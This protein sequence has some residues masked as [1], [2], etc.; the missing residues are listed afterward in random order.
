M[1][2]IKNTKKKQTPYFDFFLQTSDTNKV[3]GICYEPQQRK[4]LLE[5][6]QKKSPVKITGTKR[7]STTSFSTTNEEFK[8]AKK[9]K[10]MP[11]TTEFSYNSHVSSSMVTINEALEAEEYRTVDVT[12][13]IMNKKDQIQLVF[14]NNKQLKKVDCLIADQT[15]SIKVTLWE[16]AIDAVSSGKTYI[17]TNLKVRVFDDVKFL[18]T[19]PSTTIVETD[20]M[21]KDINLVPDELNDTIAE[22]RCVGFF[23]KITKSCIVCNN[24]LYDENT[25][26]NKIACFSCSTTMLSSECPSKHMCTLTIKLA[27]GTLQAYTCFNN[28]LQ[29]FLA[30]IEKSTSLEEITKDELEDLFLNAGTV[31]MVV[32]NSMHVIDQFLPKAI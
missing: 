7:I 2:P 16:D 8:I 28:A 25:K 13:K 11:T 6:F 18:N 30:S 24:T 22:G 31:Q 12:G 14:K 10:I 29:S 5:P 20:D 17:F 27:N 26:N 21:F 32:D 23:L 9:S 15:A 19:N 4:N 3:R 1:S